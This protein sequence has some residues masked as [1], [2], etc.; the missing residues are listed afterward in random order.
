MRRFLA[1]IVMM[2]T[3]VCTLVF[4]TQSVLNQ[5]TDAM[6]YGSSTQM[7]Y[8]L[9]KRNVEDY[10]LSVHKDLNNNG[11]KDL[12]D[13]DIEG[14]IMARLD[15]AG[16]RN[17]EVKI[18]SGDDETQEN[19]R[20]M[21]SLSPLNESELNRVKSVIGI[22]GSL[23]IGTIGD[24]TVMY[25][26]NDE[27]FDYSDTFAKVM[28]VGENPYPAFKVKQEDFDT[29]KTK[30]SEAAT[31][32]AND[33]KEARRFNEGEEEEE[34]DGSTTVYL[35]A[36]KT[37]NDTY[38][39]AFG[40]N[41]TIVSQEVKDKIIAT[42]DLNNYDSESKRLTLISDEDGEQF[43]ISKAR[44]MVNMLNGEDYG[45]DIT[46]LYQ[47]T[48]SA[49]FGGK[50][51]G[52]VVTSIVSVAVL[53]IIAVLLIAFY[54]L[55]G[56]TGTLT[57]LASV[58]VTFFLFSVLGF[59]FS[60]AA[61]IGLAII[62]CQSILITINHFER[63]K[64]ELKKGRELEKACQ[65]G[66]HKSFFT[67]LDTS[68]VLFISSLFAFL[69]TVGSF[70]TLFGVVMIGSLFTFVITTFINKWMIYWLSKG[71]KEGG[72][73]TIFGKV[74]N[75][76]HKKIAF[77]KA[78]DKKRRHTLWIVPAFIAL[79]LGVSLP[80]SYFLSKDDSFFNNSNDFASSYTLNIT[81]QDES[82]SYEA[83]T[84]KE[85][86]L[87]YIKAIGTCQ[88]TASKN[89]S[90]TM[91]ERNEKKPE[92]VSFAYDESTAFVNVIEKKD[93]EGNTYFDHY[94]SVKI[95]K[96]LSTLKRAED[97]KDVRSIIYDF[98]N[99]SDVAIK[100]INGTTSDTIIAPVTGFS[101]YKEGSLVVHS[102]LTKPTNV[103]HNYNAMFLV[104]FMISIFAFIYV[105]VRNGLKVALASLSSNVVLAG[106]AIVLLVICRIPFASFT[107]FG[108]VAIML[109]SN[110]LSVIVISRN[111]E[112]LKERGIVKSATEEERASIANDIANSSLRVTIPVSALLVVL[113]VAFFFINPSL[114]GLAISMILFTLVM[115]LVQ[116]FYQ[117][118][119]YHLL[120]SKITFK[121]INALLEKR[122]EKKNKGENTQAYSDGIVYV[123]SGAHETIVVGLNE[124]RDSS[125]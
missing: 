27:F 92:G 18:V 67:S 39:R 36:N 69:I 52:L 78:T 83:L 11:S 57:M 44:A 34:D 31:A 51:T 84:T 3:M 105:L 46:F 64:A 93:D 109:I 106:L 72:K 5:K 99:G 4:N 47:N 97:S 7:V 86:Y 50:T 28:Y 12:Q 62:V 122:R 117:I 108:L 123:D 107:S 87:S 21:I 70:K 14:E 29:L 73:Y 37:K 125:K 45:F 68:A 81:F 124:F 116:Y 42:I 90:F 71:I 112:I 19:F 20:L 61:L 25:A 24:D 23:S 16:V 89:E 119:L 8:S 76:E 74:S 115:L 15:L 17:A 26:A 96:D 120:A 100:S 113:G 43:D 58:L 49:L 114:T 1:Y 63:V 103:A 95:D 65:E 88:E 35:W 98:I 110:M 9:T 22:T 59:E 80:T 30:A 104:V 48:V 111:K 102:G 40:T 6:E 66:Y 13:I 94:F 10:D 85:V 91:Y 79:A 41:D 118:P 2:L 54:G 33:K 32:H 60:V 56:V 121:K 38:D 75:K 55:S 77:V 101:H 53:L 82:Q